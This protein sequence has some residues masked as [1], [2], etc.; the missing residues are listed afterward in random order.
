MT[1]GAA[2]KAA[3]GGLTGRPGQT[4]VIFLVLAAGAA[5]ALLGLTLVTNSN[6]LFLAA[7]SRSH[8]A[9][10]A[11]TV[12]SAKVTRAQLAKTGSCPG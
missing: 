7:F 12:S 5:A 1:G 4:V 3:S 9:Q 8:G 11:V 10:L 6:E 2:L